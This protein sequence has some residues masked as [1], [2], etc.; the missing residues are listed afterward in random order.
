MLKSARTPV[1]FTAYR[2]SRLRRDVG[3]SKMMCPRQRDM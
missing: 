3:E 1:W 2:E